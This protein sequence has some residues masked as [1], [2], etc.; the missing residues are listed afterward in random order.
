MVKISF[1]VSEKLKNEIEFWTKK[2]C[3]ESKSDLMRRAVIFGI[4]HGVSAMYQEEKP[5]RY[6]MIFSLEEEDANNL[7]RIVTATDLD[8]SFVVRMYIS[9]YISMLERY[10]K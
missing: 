6:K 1:A 5:K 8:V 9:N 2:G 4:N 3:Y 7:Y 10:Y